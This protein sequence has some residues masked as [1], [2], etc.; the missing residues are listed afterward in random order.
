MFPTSLRW[1]PIFHHLSS[2]FIIFHHLSTPI[3]HIYPYLSISIHIYRYLPLGDR[4]KAPGE[5]RA[6]LMLAFQVQHVIALVSLVPI[7]GRK[8]EGKMKKMGRKME[9]KRTIHII[10]GDLHWFTMKKKNGDWKATRG[11]AQEVTVFTRQ[12]KLINERHHPN[13][14]VCCVWPVFICRPKM[15]RAM[16]KATEKS[17]T[18]WEHGKTKPTKP[19]KPRKPIRSE[20]IWNFERDVLRIT[21]HPAWFST[22]DCKVSSHSVEPSRLPSSQIRTSNATLLEARSSTAQGR[23][24]IPGP[25]DTMGQ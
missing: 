3:F 21:S 7:P 8:K 10:P 12:Q 6:S 16:S 23:K 17:T 13:P 4:L 18:K 22:R 5:P 14:N 11:F 24:G 20:N 1:T 2:S 15:R 25:W 19:R 9:H